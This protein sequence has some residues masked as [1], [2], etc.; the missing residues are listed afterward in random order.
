MNR[1]P[2]R[3]ATRARL[4]LGAVAAATLLAFAQH[5]AAQTVYPTPEAAADALVDAVATSD[6]PAMEKVLGK[7]YGR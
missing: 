5:V 1:N 7:N 6:H 2:T 4:A 3:P